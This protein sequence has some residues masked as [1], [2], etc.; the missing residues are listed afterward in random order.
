[1]GSQFQAEI[2]GLTEYLTKNAL[3]SICTLC[4]FF[5]LVQ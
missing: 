2:T 3:H 4:D 5:E 1:M